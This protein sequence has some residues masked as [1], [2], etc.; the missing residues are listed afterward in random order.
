MKQYFS[1]SNVPN[2]IPGGYKLVRSTIFTHLHTNSYIVNL[3]GP[4]NAY[5][6]LNL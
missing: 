4:T 5:T 3:I 2:T 1:H 6:G